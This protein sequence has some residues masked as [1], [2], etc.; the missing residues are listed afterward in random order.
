VTKAQKEHMDRVAALGCL[1]CRRLGHYG[2]PAEIHHVRQG[3]LGVRGD[4]VIP[5]CDK[6]HRNGNRA[7][8]VLGKRAFEREFGF[9]E[10]DLLDDVKRLLG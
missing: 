10:L 2:T 4:Q 8:H 7:L 9:T 6:H 3:R 5:L 1:V